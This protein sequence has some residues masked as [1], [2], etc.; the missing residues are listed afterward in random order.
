MAS[1]VEDLTVNFEENGRLIVKEIS[2]LVLSKGN[3]VTII[4]KFQQWDTM[5][6][7][8]GSVADHHQSLPK[9]KGRVP[10]TIPTASAQK[11]TGTA[12]AGSAAGLVGYFRKLTRYPSWIETF[13]LRILTINLMGR[14][15]YFEI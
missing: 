2:R 12:H 11:N 13:K 7:D 6:S 8:Y 1:Q 4:F 15:S 3:R 10:D 9:N 5:S 14:I